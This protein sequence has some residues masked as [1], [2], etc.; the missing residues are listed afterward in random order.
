MAP[1]RSGDPEGLADQARL[2]ANRPLEADF[3]CGVLKPDRPSGQVDVLRLT[4][5]SRTPRS[6]PDAPPLACRGVFA[7][8]SK[9]RTAV[10]RCGDEE[11]VAEFCGH[12]IAQPS[13]FC[14]A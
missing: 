1:P 13:A 9:S 11:I 5:R 8:R 4:R 12:T 6:Q 10:E 2:S 7:G 3:A 14:R